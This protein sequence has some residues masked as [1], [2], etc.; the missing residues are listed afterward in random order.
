[1]PRGAW[2]EKRKTVC[3]VISPRG[4]SAGRSQWIGTLTR[5]SNVLFISQGRT[6]G[7]TQILSVKSKSIEPEDL[8]ANNPRKDRDVVQNSRN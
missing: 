5:Q 8:T 4:W 3:P 6:Q 2:W 1:M 7:T